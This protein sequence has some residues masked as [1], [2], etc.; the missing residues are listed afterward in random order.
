MHSL[1][2]RQTGKVLLSVSGEE[3]TVAPQLYTAISEQ[4]LNYPYAHTFSM[5]WGPN[6]NT[7]T[8]WLL[9]LVPEANLALPWYA[10]GK[11]YRLK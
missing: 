11:N 8:Q 3:N 4:V 9:R 5:V 6:C 10:W 7:F 1:K 2:K